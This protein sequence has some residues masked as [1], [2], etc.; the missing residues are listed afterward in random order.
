M[1]SKVKPSHD[2]SG[3]QIIKREEFSDDEDEEKRSRSDLSGV[4]E[5]GARDDDEEDEDGEEF[6]LAALGLAHLVVDEDSEEGRGGRGK[7]RA[8]D[9]PTDVVSRPRRNIDDAFDALLE[10]EYEDDQIGDLDEELCA[11]DG[12]AETLSG[13][14]LDVETSWLRK[15]TELA[16]PAPAP[17][18]FFTPSPSPL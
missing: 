5:Y 2:D 11:E 16:E 15:L 4:G 18:R 13:I 9:A 17:V 8:D 7:R 1:A 3:L 12:L 6:D 14:K 10:R